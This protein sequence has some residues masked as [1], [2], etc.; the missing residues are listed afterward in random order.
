MIGLFFY[1]VLAV[2]GFISYKF[3]TILRKFITSEKVRRITVPVIFMA[4]FFAP[5]SDEIVG[6]IQF[7]M[8]CSERAFLIVDEAKVK[9]KTVVSQKHQKQEITSYIL[10][11]TED[12]FVYKDTGSDEIL[13]S[14]NVYRSDGGLLSRSLNILGSSKPYLFHGTCISPRWKKTIFSD[15]NVNVI[16]Q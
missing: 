4:I 14:W 7:K 10:P 12:R 13:I 3:S 1:G 2:W 16:H 8:L 9:G 11:V 5:V 15:L 6:G